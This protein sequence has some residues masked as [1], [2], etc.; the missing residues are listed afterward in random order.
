MNVYTFS[1][2]RQHL[3]ILLERAH[4]E[5]EVY[6]KRREGQV[7]VLKPVQTSSSPLEVPGVD[8]NLST[9]EIVGMIREM[10]DQ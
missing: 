8:L 5:G 9:D 7:F 6:I 2:A 4:E 10:R 1:E 3:A